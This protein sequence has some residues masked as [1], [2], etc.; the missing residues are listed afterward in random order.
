MKYKHI[1]RQKFNFFLIYLP[2]IL[3]TMKSKDAAYVTII[4]KT[5]VQSILCL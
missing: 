1:L 4:N 3:T 2:Q 5:N